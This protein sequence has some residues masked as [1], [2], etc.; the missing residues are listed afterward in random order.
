VE[1]YVASFSR[2]TFFQDRKIG[3]RQIPHGA[4]RGR[5]AHSVHRSR[6]GSAEISIDPDRFEISTLASAPEG[7]SQAFVT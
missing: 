4:M 7:A 1:T 2:Q 3:L 6:R 5:P